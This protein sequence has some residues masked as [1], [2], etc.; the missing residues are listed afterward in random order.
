[1]DD[2]DDYSDPP[3]PSR[4]S[5]SYR[6]ATG[7][8]RSDDDSYSDS[9]LADRDEKSDDMKSDGDSSDGEFEG[10]VKLHGM[11]ETYINTQFE[12]EELENEMIEDSHILNLIAEGLAVCVDDISAEDIVDDAEGDDGDITAIATIRTTSDCNRKTKSIAKMKKYPG[13]RISA[14]D[15]VAIFKDNT[16]NNIRKLV[17]SGQVKYVTKDTIVAEFE[18]ANANTLEKYAD[19][20]GHYLIKYNNMITQKRCLSLSDKF[21]CFLFSS[22][23]TKK[24]H[25]FRSIVELVET[26]KYSS[27]YK[28]NLIP[29]EF[30]NMPL[31]SYKRLNDTQKQAV[32][33]AYTCEMFSLIHGPPGTGKSECMAV[34][35]EAMALQGKR[36]LVCA[37]SNNPVDNLLAKFSETSVFEDL[38]VKWRVLRL[39]H[40]MRV[41]KRYVRLLLKRKLGV[42]IKV[43][44]KAMEKSKKHGKKGSD[45]YRA[46]LPEL[47]DITHMRR[48]ELKIKILKKAQFVFSTQSSVFSDECLEVFLEKKFDYAIVDEASQSFSG[49]TLMAIAVSK[50]VIFAGD[51]KQLPPCIIDRDQPQLSESLF[52]MILKVL[53]K[54]KL[55]ADLYTM[56]DVQIRMNRELISVSNKRYYDGKLSSHSKVAKILLSDITKGKSNMISTKYPLLWYDHGFYEEEANYNGIINTGEADIVIK[57]LEHLHRK[58]HVPPRDVGVIVSLKAQSLLIMNM[59]EKNTTLKA[60]VGKE[61]DSFTVATVDS[62]QGLEKEVIIY[63]SVRSNAQGKI[64]FLQDERRFNVAVTRAKRMLI[65]VGNSECLIGNRADGPFADIYGHA[66]KAGLVYEH[67]YETDDDQDD[68]DDGDD[69]DDSE[70]QDDDGEEED[71][72]QGEDEVKEKEDCDQNEDKDKEEEDNDQD[73]DGEEEDDDDGE[74]EDSFEQFYDVRSRHRKFTDKK[75]RENTNSDAFKGNKRDK[76]FLHRSRKEHRVG[77]RHY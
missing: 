51:H 36:V 55:K 41:N 12:R 45:R 27:S 32:K 37:E 44:S 47:G 42:A 40:K 54:S 35:M 39:G 69:G 14:K 73:E 31:E 66:M 57:L 1:M 68:G 43:Q 76:G 2:S 20:P 56:L 23:T 74:E 71:N 5:Y 64:G 33:Q 28:A 67:Q 22:S 60:Y 8:D 6:S 24:S 10:S 34:L 49:Q 30:S 72:D 26:G 18:L 25:L 3:R 59:L 7:S 75:P 53:D 65:I 62:F 50:R 9:R 38:D 29:E 52:E 11:L 17:T 16:K 13:F 58:L 15:G 77:R 63:A 61:D 70:G 4:R 21:D 19:E 46:I 48:D